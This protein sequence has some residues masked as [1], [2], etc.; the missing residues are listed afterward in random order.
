MRNIKPGAATVMTFTAQP[1][2]DTATPTKNTTEGGG[3]SNRGDSSRCTAICYIPGT[4]S[5]EKFGSRE[6]RGKDI[7]SNQDLLCT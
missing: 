4:D 6:S 1:P 7:R 2:A 5:T 3:S